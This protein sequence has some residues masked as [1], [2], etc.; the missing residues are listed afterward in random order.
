MVHVARRLLGN[1]DLHD[2]T[3]FPRSLSIPNRNAAKQIVDDIAEADLFLELATLFLEME[4]K[5]M[6]GRKYRIPR[7]RVIVNDILEGGYRLD[8]DT[9][10]FVEDS[11]IRTTRNWGILKE[12]ET[13]IMAFVGVDVVGNSKLVRSHGKEK[14]ESIYNYLRSL[15]AAMAEK[16][17]GRLWG[18]EGD[19]GI[20]AFTFEERNQ[21]AVLAGMQILNELFVYNLSSCPLP[22]GLHV[23]LTVHNGPCEYYQ[24]GAELKGDVIKRL[25]EIDG[26]HG[27]VDTLII[28]NSVFPSL[29]RFVAEEF[30]ILGSKNHLELYSYSVRF[31]E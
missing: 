16:R 25:W 5:G 21:R 29:E 11:A 7:L 1:Y 26:K 27:R 24:N 13:Y 31:A 22:N 4:R 12:G 19:G 18:W 20:L 2:R 3:G 28:T 17:N 6:A 30:D 14:M 9:H 15:S 23:R 10:T 8:T